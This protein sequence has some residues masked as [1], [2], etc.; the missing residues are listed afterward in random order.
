MEIFYS[1]TRWKIKT[2]SAQ[3][4]SSLEGEGTDNIFGIILVK[5]VIFGFQTKFFIFTTMYGKVFH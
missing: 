3:I 5:M 4:N 1:G 2:F